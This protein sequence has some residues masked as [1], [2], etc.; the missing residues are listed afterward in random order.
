MSFFY[1]ISS[2]VNLLVTVPLS[3]IPYK[4]PTKYFSNITLFSL[5]PLQ[6]QNKSTEELRAP[7]TQ[8]TISKGCAVG[9]D[10]M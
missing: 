8:T 5:H 1:Y 4:T 3:I 9:L 2:K 10:V 6:I 7:F